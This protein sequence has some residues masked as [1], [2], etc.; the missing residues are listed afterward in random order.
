[1]SPARSLVAALAAATAV[2][3]G[4]G[5]QDKPAMT[6]DDAYLLLEKACKKGDPA[7]LFDQLDTKTQW[8]IETVQHAQ[9][10]MKRLI[11]TD[12]PPEARD[13]ALARIPAAADEDEEHPR[14]YFRRLD[15]ANE[16]LA[17]IGKRLSVGTGRP[18]GTVDE[19]AGERRA[20][21]WRE[22]GSVL[23]FAADDKGRW[24]FVELRDEWELAKV[25]ATHDLET[26]KDNAALYRARGGA[27][28]APAPAAA[29]S[30][31][32]PGDAGATRG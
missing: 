5:C 25:R 26:V 1:M 27:A 6:A 2:A 15:G 31:I 7:R 28:G 11:L 4:A 10:E 3:G 32:A 21:F 12:Y 22:G 29:P 20:I 9:R 30:T 13:R 14:R 18:V 16:R 24:G 23:K 19:V 17:D 8:S